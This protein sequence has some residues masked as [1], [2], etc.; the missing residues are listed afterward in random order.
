MELKDP[1]KTA[2]VIAQIKELFSYFDEV[3]IAVPGDLLY[4]LHSISPARGDDR[5]Y[6]HG[7]SVTK[8]DDDA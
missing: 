8:G 4:D 3:V 1:K 2:E 6:I 5:L 7:V